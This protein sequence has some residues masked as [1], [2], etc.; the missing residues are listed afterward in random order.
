MQVTLRVRSRAGA[1]RG[2]VACESL[3]WTFGNG[4]DT[5]DLSAVVSTSEAALA[6]NPDLFDDALAEVLLDGT[7]V[8]TPFLITSD[9]LTLVGGDEEAAAEQVQVTGKSALMVL[10]EWQVTPG[11]G[12]WLRRS[13]SPVYLGWQH[14]D[15]DRTS[16]ATATYV[17]RASIATTA[18][19]YN[20]PDN[21]E[22][23]LADWV[24]HS[25]GTG[26]LTL[27]Y[28]GS[29]IVTDRRQY[30]IASTAD[31]E[32]RVYLYGPGYGGIVSDE[33]K[34]ETGYTHSRRFDRVLAPGTYHLFFE[35]TSENSV[36]GDGF[37]ALSWYVGPVGTDDV[38]T[39]YSVHSGNAGIKVWRQEK[40]DPRP[41]LTVGKILT[42]LREWNQA[43]MTP[44]TASCHITTFS[45][46][47]TNDSA[48]TAWPSVAEQS[49]PPGTPVT[50][51][52]AD[53]SDFADFDC[54]LDPADGHLIVDAWVTKGSDLSG[55][56]AL[57]K[58]SSAGNGNVITYR[59]R[60]RLRTM[61]R[62]S[63]LTEDGYFTKTDSTLETVVTPRSTYLE[64]QQ[65][66]SV[67]EGRRLATRVITEDGDRESFEATFTAVSGAVP[68]VNFNWGDAVAALNRSG[69]ATGM[70]VTRWGGTRSGEEEPV[71]TA[72]LT[73]AIPYPS[74]NTFPAT[75][76]YPGGV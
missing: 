18:P 8:G 29:F 7:A 17:T 11:E 27:F 56:V 73:Y 66:S 16:W 34:Q 23:A 9:D 26:Q 57:V 59:A 30:R 67:G 33:S 71:F 46:T 31:E 72:E 44:T 41:G 45:F 48:G 14:P 58:G 75:D 63:G 24:Y 2:T 25:T 13:P 52:L 60:R 43:W 53:L 64:S 37:D 10:G 35:M 50:Q 36:G 54:R 65:S 70:T 22:N 6:A 39:T 19:K 3:S 47:A 5:A 21:W 74:T 28:G 49:W 38:V 51:V 61:T 40:D 76:L 42:E 12:T 32:H 55:T 62:A 4:I 68:G 1:I 15:F 69:A 20:Q